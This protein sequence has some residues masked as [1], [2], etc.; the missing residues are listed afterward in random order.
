MNKSFLTVMILSLCLIFNNQAFAK[1]PIENDQTGNG[2]TQEVVADVEETEALQHE[3]NQP[4]MISVED[5]YEDVQ[6]VFDRFM[7]GYLSEDLD[8]VLETLADNEHVFF[9]GS[10]SRT[11]L[12]GKE[13][14]KQAFQHDFKTIDGFDVNVPWLYIFGEGDIAWLNAIMLAVYNSGE[15]KRVIESRLT[16]MFQKVDDQ[17]KII[18]LHFSLPAAKFEQESVEVKE[19]KIEEDIND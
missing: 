16:M 5:G 14:I 19:V 18:S 6:T 8:K 9:I 11:I 10:G 17:W 2:A 12:V 13:Q 4:I 1:G 3:S 15:D 7:V